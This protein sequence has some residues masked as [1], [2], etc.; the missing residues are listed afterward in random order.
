MLVF[1]GFGFLL[2]KT[3]GLKIALLA[4]SFAW[5]VEFSQLYRA[6]WIDAIRGTIPGRLVLGTTFNWIDL[7]AYAV[8]IGLGAGVE[9]RLRQRCSLVA[10][11]L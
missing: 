2:P 10:K 7:A 11:P 3:S 8:G 9:G 4:L 1:L 6:P 5:G